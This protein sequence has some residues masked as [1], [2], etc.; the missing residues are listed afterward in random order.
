MGIMA[1][2]MS[3]RTVLIVTISQ[4]IT[5]QIPDVTNETTMA[6]RPLES[7]EA[8]TLSLLITNL[9]RGNVEMFKEAQD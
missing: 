7:S 3:Q 4:M 5:H 6:Y 8:V 1:V 9:N 2:H